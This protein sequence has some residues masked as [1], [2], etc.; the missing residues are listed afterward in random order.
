MRWVSFCLSVFLICAGTV[1]Q[2]QQTVDCTPQQSGKIVQS[3]Q[4]AKGMVVGATGSIGDTETFARWFGAFSRPR[5]EVVRRNFKQLVVAMR[6]GAI[7]VVCS[8]NQTDGCTDGEYAWVYPGQAYR[9]VVCP[10]FFDLPVITLLQPGSL[11]SEN[12]TRSGTMIHE[13][14]HF[15]RVASTEDHCYSRGE[16]REMAQ[17]DP[18]KAIENADSYQYF[19][20]DARFFDRQVLLAKP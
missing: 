11:A 17:D 15:T 5:A 1:S 10:S 19:A 18:G 9:V 12:G 8:D 7:A 2:A 6:S 16:C 14:S 13:I 4:T 20:E 3:L